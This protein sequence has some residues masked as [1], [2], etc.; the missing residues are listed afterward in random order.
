MKKK[1]RLCEAEIHL[2]VEQLIDD[3]S[4]KKAD[5]MMIIAVGLEGERAYD[6]DEK[7]Y[8]KA[9]EF[10]KPITIIMNSPNGKQFG[11]YVYG[12]L[13]MMKHKKYRKEWFKLVDNPKM[14]HLGT[15][16]VIIWP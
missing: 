12:M 16:D 6:L 4:H 13:D 14:K 1:K 11:L 3:S 5:E 7:I 15:Y 2:K 10:K 8:K 9:K